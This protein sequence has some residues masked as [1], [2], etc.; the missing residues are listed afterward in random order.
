M[1]Q[2]NVEII[3][4]L[5]EALSESDLDRIFACLHPEIE[6][7]LSRRL[8]DPATFRGHEGGRDLLHQQRQVW[9][10]ERIEPEA[11]IAASE[12]VVVVPTHFVATGRGSE[13]DVSAR[14]TYVWELRDGLV[15]R[16][17]MYQSKAEAFEAVGLPGSE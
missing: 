9:S 4:E 10:S 2:D 5:Y 1:P 12:S 17:T 3:R 8:L 14:A 13:I 16:V 11:Y 7:D 6:V 15:V